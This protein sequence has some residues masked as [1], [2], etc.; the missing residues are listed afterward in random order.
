MSKLV[1]CKSCGKEVAKGSKSC[2][3]CGR[4]NR[5]FFA[6]HKIITGI[7]ILAIIFIIGGAAGGGDNNSDGESAEVSNNKPVE[8]KKEDSKIN[9]DNFLKIEMGIAYEDVIALLGEGVE[10]S[11]SE[12]AGIKTAIYTWNGKGIEN[13][14]VTIQDGVVMGKAQLGLADMDAKVTLEKFN[15]TNEG[16]SYEE[17]KAIL[18]EG[19]IMSETKIMDSTAIM[20]GWINK[21]G[22]NMNAIFQ[23][24]TLT[25]K[26]QFNLK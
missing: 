14:N 24:G 17:V 22:S 10:Q 25:T 26:S 2:P 23:D 20:Y 9:Y 8:T 19:E 11:S 18:G 4:D 12:V 13:M 3:S 1:G 15:N 7:L 16:M 21:N 5:S 6:K